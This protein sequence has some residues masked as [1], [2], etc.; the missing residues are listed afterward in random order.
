MAA[1][2]QRDEEVLRAGGWNRR[3]RAAILGGGLV[4]VLGLIVGLTRGGDGSSPGDG[5]ATTHAPTSTFHIAAPRVS[6]ND[7]LFTSTWARVSSEEGAPGSGEWVLIVSAGLVNSADQ[8]LTIAEPIT[9]HGGVRSAVVVD[10]AEVA[11]EDQLSTVRPPSLTTI[12]PKAHVEI[13]VKLRL[14]CVASSKHRSTFPKLTISIP[15]D[16]TIEPATFSFAQLFGSL[17]SLRPS[18]C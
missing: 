9:V 12:A 15:L 4:V 16:R 10:V 7:V 14:P 11:K 17:R 3:A 18:G 6:G 13:W 1:E 8:P 5:S 2:G